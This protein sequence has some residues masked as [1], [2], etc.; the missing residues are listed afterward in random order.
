MNYDYNQTVGF[1]ER[2][3]Q[4][5]VKVGQTWSN[6]MDGPIPLDLVKFIFK[7]WLLGLKSITTYWCWWNLRPIRL[8]D[9]ENI[10][11]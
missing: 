10:A 5:L 1:R 2:C 3:G 6:V 7:S 8:S 9:W 11:I 4:S